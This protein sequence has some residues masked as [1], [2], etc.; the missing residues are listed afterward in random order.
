M[1]NLLLVDVPAY[2]PKYIVSFENTF[3]RPTTLFPLAPNLG[4]DVEEY[5]VP[6]IASELFEDDVGISLLYQA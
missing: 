4:N 1:I 6:K 5:D 2:S 3:L